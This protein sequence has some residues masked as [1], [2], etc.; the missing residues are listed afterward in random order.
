MSA[1]LPLPLISSGAFGTI[2]VDGLGT[3]IIWPTVYFDFDA[4]GRPQI[5]PPAAPL[6]R[7]D[8]ADAA[9]HPAPTQGWN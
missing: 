1:G 4:A 5:T 2:S 8:G 3:G 6:T 7:A 9:I